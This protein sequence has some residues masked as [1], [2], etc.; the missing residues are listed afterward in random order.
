[1]LC[2]V[3]NSLII[4]PFMICRRKLRAVQEPVGSEAPV[5]LWKAQRSLC[6]SQTPSTLYFIQPTLP[7]KLRWG[8]MVL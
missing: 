4:T 1:M 6:A 5:E 7:M 3:H 8:G 2:N